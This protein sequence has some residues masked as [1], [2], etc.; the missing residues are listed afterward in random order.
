MP[1]DRFNVSQR[2]F[3]SLHNRTSHVQRW[4]YR[5]FDTGTTSHGDEVSEAKRIGVLPDDLH[6][7]R[8]VFVNDGRNDIS[9]L[10]GRAGAV[11]TM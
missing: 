3:W 6:P 2:L 7:A 1:L 10:S 5:Y 11:S 8:P 9:G 4:F